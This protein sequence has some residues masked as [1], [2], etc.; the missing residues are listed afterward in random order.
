M[1]LQTFKT[2]V[3]NGQAPTQLVV[4]LCA[5]NFFIADQYINTLCTKTGKEKK[6]VNSIFEQE[7]AYDKVACAFG[8]LAGAG[9]SFRTENQSGPRCRLPLLQRNGLGV[10]GIGGHSD[11]VCGTENQL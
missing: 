10:C 8:R 2:N 1:D 7:S 4:L 3:L 6:I 9:V 5:E 11:A